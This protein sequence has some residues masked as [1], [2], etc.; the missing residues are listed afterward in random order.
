MLLL[1]GLSSIWLFG[2]SAA[3]HLVTWS[4]SR[5]RLLRTV[6][7][8]NI[9][10]VIAATSTAIGGTV[11]EGGQRLVPLVAVWIF[12]VVGVAVTVAHI[13]VPAV[14]RVVL[15]VLTGLTGILAAPGLIA[16][17]P[18]EAIVAIIVG[19]VLY[20]VG[21]VVYALRR[22]DPFPRIF[23]YHEIFHLLVI[24]GSIVFGTV[25][26]C[27]VLPVTVRVGYEA[28]APETTVAETLVPLS[29]DSGRPQNGWSDCHGPKKSAD[30]RIG[31][32]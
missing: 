31:S 24:A 11:L 30:P 27:W 16:A 13:R 18:L 5:L 15:Y 20:I 9:Y 28:H 12:A 22:P 4:P 17:L 29:S 3:Y 14:A 10:I 6:D 7:H 8:G 1:Y 2:C 26:W 19:S 32:R 25:I 21:G 23:G